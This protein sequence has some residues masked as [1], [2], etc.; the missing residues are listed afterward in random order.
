MSKE[1]TIRVR[2][3]QSVLHLITINKKTTIGEL[4]RTIDQRKFE[5]N[6]YYLVFQGKFYCNRLY[7]SREPNRLVYHGDPIETRNYKLM[8]KKLHK[9]GVK[10]HSELCCGIIP[11]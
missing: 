2:E 4:L 9:I 8:R 3:Q 1:F 11:N 6:K 5:N 10:E 7:D